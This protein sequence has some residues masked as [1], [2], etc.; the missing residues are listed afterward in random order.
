M[1]PFVT[2]NAKSTLVHIMA[3]HQIYA[4]ELYNTWQRLLNATAT[5]IYLRSSYW[6][7]SSNIC[8]CGNDH[9][10]VPPYSIH[11]DGVIKWKHFAHDL[12]FVRGIHRSQVNSPH[13]GQWHGAFSLIC[14]WT[15]GWVSNRY[16]CDLRRHCANYDVI[17]RVTTSCSYLISINS[18]W[19][20]QTYFFVIDMIC[21]PWELY[22]GEHHR[23]SGILYLTDDKSTAVQIMGGLVIRDISYMHQTNRVSLFSFDPL[24]GSTDKY[25]IRYWSSIPLPITSHARPC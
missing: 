7:K 13:K 21:I 19:N 10:F 15:N 18:I 22:S 9:C 4:K 14:A 20:F 16:A 8:Q 12:T 3:W 2:N 5:V 24:R 1:F 11:H 17:V 6:L 23:S 25:L